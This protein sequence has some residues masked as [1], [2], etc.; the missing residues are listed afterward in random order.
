M[1]DIIVVGSGPAGLS[2]AV[3]AKRAGLSVLLIE[4]ITFG[5]GQIT[6][7]HKVDNYLGLPEIGGYELGMKF[8]DHAVSLGVEIRD[9]EVVSYRYDKETKLWSI[10]LLTNENLQTKTIIFAG[11][12]NHR[13]LNISGEAEF[14]GKGVSYCATCDGAFFRGKTVAVVGG[15]NTALYD[16]L[17]LADMAQKV[18]VI[19]R[20][21]QFRGS[22]D[23]IQKLEMKE[24]VEFVLG[25]TPI[26]ITGDELV[27]NIELNSGKKLQVDG[28]F[29]AVGMEPM[30]QNLPDSVKLDAEGYVCA[31]ETGITSADGFFVAGDVRQKALRQIVTAVSD[32]ANAATSAEKYIR[33]CSI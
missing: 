27:E 10:D 28:V 22:F 33:S 2:A 32:G 6:E 5:M 7:S 3:Y 25:D 31:D 30:T 13:H 1:Q 17:Y 4:K 12:A 26:C 9:G 20:R 18:Y 19:H 11:G 14:V 21:E 15:G 16:A 24:N 23:A 29:V 8:R